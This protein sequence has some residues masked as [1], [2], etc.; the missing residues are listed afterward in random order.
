VV[1]GYAA[2]AIVAVPRA[3]T[4]LTTYAGESSRAY[5]ADLCAGLALLGVGLAALTERRMRR[6]GLLALATG[7][8][9]FAPD[10]DGW[11][12]GPALVRSLGALPMPLFVAFVFH[13]VVAFPSGRLPSRFARGAVVAGYLAT[14]SMSV[15]RALFRDP[16]L[17][18]YCWRNCIDNSLLVSAHPGLARTLDSVWLG[19][20]LALG[21]LLVAICGW[22]L[23]TGTPSARR[24]LWPVLVPGLL[25]G[26]AEA[27]Y[28]VALLSAPLEDPS[29]ADFSWIFLARSSSAVLLAAGIAW[30]LL[31]VRRQRAAVSRLAT[32]LGDAP[33]PGTL[34]AVLAAALRDPGLEVAYWLPDSRRFVDSSGKPMEAPV[35]GEGRAVTPIVR[36]GRAV[37]AVVH[38]A[39]LSDEPGVEQ[40]IGAAARLA[41]ENERLQAEVLA[42][43]ED[44]RASRARIVETGDAERR[45]L[46][47]D[48]HDGA[49]QRLLALS[50]ELRLARAG[51]EADGDSGLARAVA[52]AADEAEAALKELRELAHGIHP[53]ILTEA[54][55]APA[56][57]TLAEEAPLPVELGDVSQRRHPPAIETTTYV[58]VAEAILDAAGRGA[59]FVSVEVVDEGAR[60][61]VTVKDDGAPRSSRLVHLEDRVGALGGSL[62]VAPSGLRAEIPCE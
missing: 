3:A 60:L 51:A 32:E 33:R 28:A 37:A 26:A 10:W 13:L 57:E 49:Q 46:E 17:D 29:R 14:G 38:D 7:V 19:S 22:R 18:P 4:P 45:R 39:A 11:D 43:L 6:I 40:E 56:L 27:A 42:Q 30:I 44:L 62:E 34:R 36:D 58:T 12:A 55:L 21:V 50:Y 31:R 8:V 41:V 59:G 52:S 25:A 15:G 5:V 24:S 48:L 53:A 35:R 23:M 47:R 54:G 1:L 16:F 2:A 9:W 61:A 20:A